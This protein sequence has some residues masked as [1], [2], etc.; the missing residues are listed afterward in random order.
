VSDPYII[1]KAPRFYILGGLVMQEISRQMLKE[2]GADWTRRAPER[3]VYIDRYQ[4]ELF[5]NGP[6]KIVFLTRVLPT[7]ATVGYEEITA[8]RVTKINGV[9]LQ[10]LNDVPTALEK[11]ENGFH[12]IEFDESPRVIYLD[13]AQVGAVEQLVQQQYRLPTLKRLE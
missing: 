1:D 7:P 6:K 11:P 2:F 12:K 8:V 10:S 5:E 3:A 13:A 4:S 9:E